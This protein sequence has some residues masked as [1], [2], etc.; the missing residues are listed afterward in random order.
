MFALRPSPSP[1]LSTTPLSYHFSPPSSYLHTPL[2]NF[3]N[4]PIST[5]GDLTDTLPQVNQESDS[6]GWL[7]LAQFHKELEDAKE[8][9]AAL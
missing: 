4:L 1:T 8:V 5:M 9:I 6:A 2:L 7:K 3:N